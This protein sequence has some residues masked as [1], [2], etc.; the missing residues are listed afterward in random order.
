MEKTKHQITTT[1]QKKTKFIPV[2]VD[3]YNHFM[4]AVDKA[5]SSTNRIKFEHCNR[6]WKHAA[7][8][9]ELQTCF[10][11][12]WI[13]WK[14]S[15]SRNTKVSQTKFMEQLMN[16]LVQKFQKE[17][18]TTSPQNNSRSSPKKRSKKTIFEDSLHQF[19]RGIKKEP[20][21]VCAKRAV[22]MCSNCNVAVHFKC[23]YQH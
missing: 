9:A 14:Q 10:S 5:D 2:L 7:F 21:V 1:V 22:Y 17:K 18:N 20:C 11:N 23:W 8:M 19:I 4:N 15:S 12:A 6:T 13:F 16:Q 3:S